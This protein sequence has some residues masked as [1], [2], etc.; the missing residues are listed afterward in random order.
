MSSG[1]LLLLPV[2]VCALHAT[3]PRLSWAV[4]ATP[5]SLLKEAASK[6]RNLESYTV[7][8]FRYDEYPCNRSVLHRRNS[9]V[10]PFR[11]RSEDLEPSTETL[12]TA[13]GKLISAPG[14]GRFTDLFNGNIRWSYNEDLKLYSKS[15]FDP[16]KE[17][18]VI[19]FALPIR[20]QFDQIS[21]GPDETLSIGGRQY[22]CTVIHAHYRAGA[23]RTAWIDK[24]QGFVV[25][26]T[27]VTS[28]PQTSVTVELISIKVN[29]ALPDDLFTFKPPAD[30]HQASGFPCSPA[31]TAV[32]P[33]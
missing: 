26:W 1:S 21:L 5:E 18:P 25:K 20:S 15:A 22:D 4:D 14:C 27:Q 8:F 11:F 6:I 16:S 28:Q 2:L 30:W 33:K 12:C 29:P 10:R 24:L 23:Y 17:D 31:W 7:E 19:I 3:H 9:F 32:Q 13:D